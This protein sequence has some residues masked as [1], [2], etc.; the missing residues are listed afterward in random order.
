[1]DSSLSGVAYR[2]GVV[3]I[4]NILG[5]HGGAGRGFEYRTRTT[6]SSLLEIRH[7]YENPDLEE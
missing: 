2:S 5:G 4:S 1:M 7:Y 6:R 3:G